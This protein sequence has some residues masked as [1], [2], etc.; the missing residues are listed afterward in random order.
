MR[1]VITVRLSSEPKRGG[2]SF[3]LNHKRINYAEI[4]NLIQDGND[5]SFYCSDYKNIDLPFTYLGM[6]KTK[7]PFVGDAELA[8]RIIRAG[9]LV[10]YAEYLEK[11]CG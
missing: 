11:L 5:V 9:G 1:V 4:H 10:R 2:N 8:N 7:E 6:I 3:Y